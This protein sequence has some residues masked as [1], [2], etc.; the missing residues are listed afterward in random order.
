MNF[1]KQDDAMR[2]TIYFRHVS[3]RGRNFLKWWCQLSA[4]PFDL[5]A[6]DVF[7]GGLFNHK[8]CGAKSLIKLTRSC[9]NLTENFTKKNFDASVFFK[10]FSGTNTRVETSFNLIVLFTKSRLLDFHQLQNSYSSIH[11]LQPRTISVLHDQQKVLRVI[12]ILAL[13]L[14][15]GDFTTASTSTEASLVGECGSPKCVTDA[16][17]L[18]SGS[19]STDSCRYSRSSI[20]LSAG[21]HSL[22][23]VR[24][25][26][27]CRLFSALFWLLRNAEC[28]G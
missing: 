6:L 9:Q 27:V 23:P 14:L 25:A 8:V 5:I 26:H 12:E 20:S 24:F 7:F 2:C 19:S 18:W 28:C 21:N 11:C 17:G 22:P 13:E 16:A 1:V 4:R 15:H 3:W 10:M